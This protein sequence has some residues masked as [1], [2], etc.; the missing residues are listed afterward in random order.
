MIPYGYVY[1]GATH[2][3]LRL[4]RTRRAVSIAQRGTGPFSFVDLYDAR[5]DHAN[6]LT[7]LRD[8]NLT[9][10]RQMNHAR[11]ITR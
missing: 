7:Q 5:I 4:S 3:L 2:L 11:H 6:A 8:Y 9:F 10:E 1:P